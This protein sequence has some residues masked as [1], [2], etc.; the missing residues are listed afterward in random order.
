MGTPEAMFK[1]NKN[2]CSN[3]NAR[4]AINRKPTFISFASYAIY[5]QLSSHWLMAIKAA[6]CC[7][8]ALMAQPLH[9]T[10]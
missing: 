9:S 5:K 4:K 8:Y 6:C 10:G 1:I 3:M 7:S 2:I